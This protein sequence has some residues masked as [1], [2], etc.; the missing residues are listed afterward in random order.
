MPIYVRAYGL[1][2]EVKFAH[3]VKMKEGEVFATMVTDSDNP[4]DAV[5]KAPCEG[6]LVACQDTR[7]VKPGDEIFTWQPDIKL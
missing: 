3:H 5:F 1:I 2:D 6:S 7:F 4:D